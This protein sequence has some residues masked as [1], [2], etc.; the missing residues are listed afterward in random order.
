MTSPLSS[1]AAILLSAALFLMG[2]GL[3]GTLTPLRAHAEGFPDIAVGALGFW[4]FSGFLAGCF[5]G[6]HVLAR[7][8]SIRA[9]TLAAVVVAISILMQ[10]I[11]TGPAAWFVARGLTGLGIAVLFVSVEN[12]LSD[13]AG[14]AMR[15][16]FLT[17]YVAVNF[18][19][20]WLGQWLLL[21]GAPESFE[22]FSIAAILYCLCL[23]P[24]GLTPLPTPVPQPA[25]NVDPARLF[26]ISPVGVAGCITAGLANGAFWTLAPLYA[27]SLG[28]STREIALFMSVFIAGG[29]LAQWPLGR[30][31]DGMDRRWIIAAIS[32]AASVCGLILGVVGWLLARAPA[33]FHLFVLVLGAAMLPLYALAIAHANDRVPRAEFIETSAG[34]LIIAVAASI[35]GPLFASLL[36][37]LAGP[38]ALFL[39]IALVHAAM[40]FYAFTRMRVK[41][42]APA[43]TRERFA[44]VAQGSPAAFSLDPRAPAYAESSGGRGVANPGPP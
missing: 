21:L 23:V 33:A 30:V 28:F 14:H 25:P 16:H 13:R 17:L 24:M 8:G 31:S 43:E 15:N 20:L 7:V 29:A 26:A 18:G 39:F 37:A 38:Y 42:P 4:Y 11:W 34:L 44:L 10:P 2:T 5:A 36:M 35:P 32:T 1:L 40:A 22:L 27:Q 19:A 3:I 12:W 41:E 9:F 6:P